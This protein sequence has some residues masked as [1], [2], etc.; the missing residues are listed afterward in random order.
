MQ[1]CTVTIINA[2]AFA[3][4]ARTVCMLISKASKHLQ[5]IQALGTFTLALLYTVLFGMYM[6]L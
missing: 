1:L 6:F 3:K 2:R 5:P 4:F